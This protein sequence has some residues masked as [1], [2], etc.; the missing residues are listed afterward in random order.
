MNGTRDL[1]PLSADEDEP[2][3]PV[4]PRRAWRILSPEAVGRLVRYIVTSTLERGVAPNEVVALYADLVGDEL[5]VRY[6]DR[7][8]ML[9][10]MP[11]DWSEIENRVLDLEQTA[12]ER[13][14]ELAA[15]WRRAMGVAMQG[16]DPL[17][18]LARLAGVRSAHRTE[19][20]IFD[21]PEDLDELEDDVDFDALDAPGDWPIAAPDLFD[22]VDGAQQ[23]MRRFAIEERLERRSAGGRAA[24]AVS[25]R[26]TWTR[27]TARSNTW[28]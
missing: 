14:L 3:G 5:A 12:R 23:R 15:A 28:T 26:S 16:Q 25:R 1:I 19:R 27:T 10:E 8:F 21:D 4:G 22:L 18:Q 24:R 9:R 2:A 17:E 13:G 20:S 11:A 7:R 6:A